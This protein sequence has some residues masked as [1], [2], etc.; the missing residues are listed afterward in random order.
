M[1]AAVG[2]SASSVL[3]IGRA[4]KL[5]PHRV[6]GFKLSR[7]PAFVA[8]LRDIVG[9]YLDPPAHSLVLPVD[10]KSQTQALN[11]PGPGCR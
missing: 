11:P 8:K 2:I 10:E 4:R 1:A 6:R 3:R 5:Q 9:L 7:D